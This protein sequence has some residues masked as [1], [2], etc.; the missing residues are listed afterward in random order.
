QALFDWGNGPAGAK[1]DSNPIQVPCAVLVNEQTA[2]AAEALA[3][4]LRQSASSLILGSRTAGRATVAEEFA[5][6]DGTRLRI[7]TAPIRLADGSPF[8][9][10]GLEPDLPMEVSLEEQRAYFA[11]AFATLRRPGPTASSGSAPQI[12]STASGRPGRRPR[13]N[14]AEL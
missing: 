13:V 10:H 11:D 8:P 1:A 7:A 9:L 2:G 6:K 5:L 12:A 14:E 4:V 3:A